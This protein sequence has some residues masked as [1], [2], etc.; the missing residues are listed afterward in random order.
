[1]ISVSISSLKNRLSHFLRHVKK[2]ETIIIMDRDKPI[3]EILPFSQSKENQEGDL[4]VLESQGLIRRGDPSKLKTW[5]PS[6]QK[7]NVGVL[8]ALLKERKE[9]R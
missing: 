8:D 3:A 2:G 1:M 4:A 7:K 9:G 5:K 6:L